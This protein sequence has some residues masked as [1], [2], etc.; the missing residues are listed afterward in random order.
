MP[1]ERNIEDDG[2]ILID[3]KSFN[4]NMFQDLNLGKSLVLI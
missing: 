1:K 3:P 4:D 2:M